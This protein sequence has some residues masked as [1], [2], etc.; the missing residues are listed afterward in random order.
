MCVIEI[1]TF[2]LSS[3]LEYIRRPSGALK[4]NFMHIDDKQSKN[5]FGRRLNEN[6]I[7]IIKER[8]M[9][10]HRHTM[11]YF[12][13]HTSARET[14]SILFE[15]FFLVFSGVKNDF[16]QTRWRISQ[17][18]LAPLPRIVRYETYEICVSLLSQSNSFERIPK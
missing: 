17:M 4:S 1:F 18:S 14:F 5:E 2:H 13:Q 9:R 8:L 6:A 3:E 15:H 10:Q 11:T 16:F 7:I 12:L